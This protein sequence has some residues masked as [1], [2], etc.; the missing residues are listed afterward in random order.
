M[1]R[2][3]FDASSPDLT[4]V[5]QAIFQRLRDQHS[6]NHLLYPTTS[7][8]GFEGYL[9]LNPPRMDDVVV[10]Q[11]CVMDV[12]WQLVTEGILAPG[13]NAGFRTIISTRLATQ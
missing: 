6:W 3:Q 9:D 7:N 12:F 11:R 10:F 13:E 4:L 1:E 2:L 5:R 8:H